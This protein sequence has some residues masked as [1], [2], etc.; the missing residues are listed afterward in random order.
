MKNI[1]KIKKDRNLGLEVLR[2]ILCFWVITFH[3]FHNKNCKTPYTKRKKYHVP[4]FFFISFYF[5]YP[6]LFNKNMDKMKFR[7]VRLLIPYLVWPLIIFL[8]ENI[9][10]LLCKTN[11]INR[12]ITFNDLK[13]QIILGRNFM[14]H[15]WFLFNLL[16]LTILF[17]IMTFIF[18]YYNFLFI[19]QILGISSYILQYSRYN[20]TFFDNYT[21]AIRHSI[22]Y[23]AETIP[24]ASSAFLLSSLNFVEKMKEHR[25]KTLFIFFMFLYLI[26]KYNI[27]SYL[28]GYTY[29]GIENNIISL[30]LFNIFILI[31]FEN[32]KP[33]I[34]NNLLVILSRYT[35]GIYCIHIYI[36]YIVSL[37]FNIK[38]TLFGCFI[39]YFFGYIISLIG[40]KI[41][42]RNKLRFLF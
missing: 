27:F 13:I 3:C 16:F 17:F 28:S 37:I 21:N 2:A 32:L 35:Q 19:L 20:Y 41:F 39:I 4:C 42:H 7:L 34:L 23:F 12:I 8:I 18:A 15:L 1:D 6:I 11:I 36:S 10:F 25:K 31:P 40:S 5:L 29:K 14:A 22:G 30:L 24:F 38:G 33:K 26:I 9:S